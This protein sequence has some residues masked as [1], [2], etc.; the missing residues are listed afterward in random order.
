MRQHGILVPLEEE[1]YVRIHI[2][3]LRQYS[4]LIFAEK[5]SDFVIDCY[6]L[7]RDRSFRSSKFYEFISVGY[8]VILYRMSDK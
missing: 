1:K 5:Q 4:E 6:L 2:G 3:L 7:Y 8:S